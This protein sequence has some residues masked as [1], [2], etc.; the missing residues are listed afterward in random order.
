MTRL[1]SARLRYVA[2][3]LLICGCTQHAGASFTLEIDAH[4]FDPVAADRK[5][6]E[7]GDA[8][9]RWN[10]V[11]S[12]LV[13]SAKA[14][15]PAMAKIEIPED[16]RYFI[17]VWHGIQPIRSRTFFVEI[18]GQSLAYAGFPC[19]EFP[20]LGSDHYPPTTQESGLM[21]WT[22]QEIDLKQGSYQFIL[23]TNGELPAKAIRQPAIFGRA[24]ITDDPDLTPEPSL[25][26]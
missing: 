10:N 15:T 24:L 5:E 21:V 6:M 25:N 22:K 17:W 14:I 8:M 16:G 20:E 26:P 3:I 18:D 19:G 4:A 12:H 23:T 2:L 13:G 9:W 11:K 1:I 7:E